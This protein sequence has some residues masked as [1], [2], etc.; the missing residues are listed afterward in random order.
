MAWNGQTDI[1]KVT[2]IPT[3]DEQVGTNRFKEEKYQGGKGKE[4]AQGWIWNQ[5]GPF[6]LGQY[7]RD[8][9]E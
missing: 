5:E 8:W 2:E 6:R 7:G 3:Y 1:W 4:I 9:Q